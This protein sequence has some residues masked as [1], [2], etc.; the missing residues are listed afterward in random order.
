VS[1]ESIGGHTLYLTIS[2]GFL[3]VKLNADG[4]FLSSTLEQVDSL[5]APPDLSFHG[6]WLMTPAGML[7]CSATNGSV[8]TVDLTQF[9]HISI[10]WL[11]SQGY[12][13]VTVSLTGVSTQ[14]GMIVFDDVNGLPQIE[15]AYLHIKNK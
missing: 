13:P 2:P 14:T 3:E 15:S 11:K 6:S 10:D 1:P 5:P 4:T 9:T 8:L 7:T 12:K